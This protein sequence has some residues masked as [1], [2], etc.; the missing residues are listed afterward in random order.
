MARALYG[1]II[2]DIKG[3]IGGMTFQSNVSGKIIRL[4]PFRKK[5]N[6]QKQMT[7]HQL[8]LKRLH[9]W[10]LLSLSDQLLWNTFAAHHT[11][12]DPVGDLETLTGL[13]WYISINCNLEL[14]SQ[15]IT[16]TPPAWLA[17]TAP[18]AATLNL[19][20]S[21]MTLTVAAPNP[22][23]YDSLICNITPP[24]SNSSYKVNGKFRLCH[25]IQ[26][27]L[28]VPINLTPYWETYFGL[29]WLS[30]TAAGS[31]KIAIEIYCIDTVSGL[32]SPVN[33]YIED[34]IPGLFGIGAMIIETDFI[35]S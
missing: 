11:F 24:I 9:E 8:F 16:P 28:W 34:V 7:K 5:G 12:T 19:T 35:V 20:P 31:F 26:P 32:A 27:G 3:S 23:G 30:L 14:I 10:H 13:G 33:R 6:T 15:P 4:K 29:N 21:A 25:I 1:D 17:P 18:P 22:A 2:T